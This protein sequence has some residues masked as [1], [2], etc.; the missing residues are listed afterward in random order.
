MSLEKEDRVGMEDLSV[1]LSATA[2]SDVIEGAV[3]IAM[4]SRGIVPIDLF[5]A[6]M[7]LIKPRHY[8]LTTN[9]IPIDVARNSLV[10]NFLVKRPE[11]THVLFWD[12]DVLPP[13]DALL[14][15]WAHNEAIVSGLYFRKAPPHEPLMSVKV[16]SPTG[17][18]GMSPFIHWEEDKSYYVDGVGMGFCLIR[19]DVFQNIEH[20][21]F[22]FGTWS[23]DYMFCEKAQ[24]AGYKIKI[25][26]SI[27]L[28]HVA[29][30]I[31][32]GQDFYL[33]YKDEIMAAQTFFR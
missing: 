16:V 25:D 26:T 1:D 32:V 28:Q 11:A 20:P 22:E 19:R 29:D 17:I 12:D 13:R 15:L 2:E 27:K 31:Q 14:R 4:P 10:A 30:R 9:E 21:W 23:E 5:V 18:T 33:R 6:Y 7:G 8:F 3:F 24:E